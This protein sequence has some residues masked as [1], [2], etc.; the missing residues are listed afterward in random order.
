MI[1]K[2]IKFLIKA[3]LWV[4]FIALIVPVGYF[5]V[6]M[7]QPMDLPE[8]KGLTYYQYL[9]WER[10]EQEKHLKEYFTENPAT[11]EEYEN[12]N[13]C[14]VISRS[15]GH[16]GR[17]FSQPVILLERSVIE[18]KPFDFMRFL[19]NWWMM[20]EENHLKTLHANSTGHSVCRI[21]DEIPDDYAL[22]VG[23]QLPREEVVQ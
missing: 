16:S 10:L 21:P 4:V 1:G 23:A 14:A 5:A 22:S 15:F 6:R 8:Y 17:F 20:F 3:V 19:P 7:G 12:I 9:E 18:D 13:G 11:Q 2:I